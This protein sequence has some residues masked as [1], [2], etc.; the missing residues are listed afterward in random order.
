LL[1][2]ALGFVRQGVAGAEDE[3]RGE[4][5]DAN[6]DR[7]TNRT[8][9]RRGP[10]SHEAAQLSAE[11]QR[12]AYGQRAES[13]QTASTRTRGRPFGRVSRIA[14]DAALFE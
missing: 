2:V 14:T 10:S 9:G 4:H 12:A 8:P 1:R 5:S 11:R 3:E 7:R 13:G 6:G